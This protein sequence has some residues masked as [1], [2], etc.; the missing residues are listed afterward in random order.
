MNF[1][2]PV[3]VQSQPEKNSF[4]RKNLRQWR[5]LLLE[6]SRKVLGYRPFLCHK[7]D[8]QGQFRPVK[9]LTRKKIM[10]ICN[11]RKRK[12][13][14]F[15]QF[16]S[17]AC[18]SPGKRF[19]P[20]LSFCQSFGSF[21]SWLRFKLNDLKLCNLPVHLLDLSKHWLTLIYPSIVFSKLLLKLGTDK[22]ACAGSGTPTLIYLTLFAPVAVFPRFPYEKTSS[23][24]RILRC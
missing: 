11:Q 17:A 24:S 15:A 12:P 5:V 19:L 16:L 3:K 14:L 18:S 23:C 10:L 21:L 7:L 1:F 20:P 6:F 9:V 8:I 2:I 13:F 22:S 4:G